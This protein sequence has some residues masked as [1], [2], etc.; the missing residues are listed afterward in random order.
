MKCKGVQRI[1]LMFISDWFNFQLLR[2][3]FEISEVGLLFAF[4]CLSV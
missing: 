2:F 4:F 1:C 3:W